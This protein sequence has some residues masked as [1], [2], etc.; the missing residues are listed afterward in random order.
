MNTLKIGDRFP[1]LEVE[2]VPGGKLQ[3]PGDL[4]GRYAVVLFYRG[5]W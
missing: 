3:L 1:D 2:T 5:K 4:R